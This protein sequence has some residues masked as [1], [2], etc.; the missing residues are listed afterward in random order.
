MAGW[1]WRENAYVIKDA[2][3]A[4]KSSLN[5]LADGT[6]LSFTHLTH[7]LTSN[8]QSLKE[9]ALI[10]EKILAELNYPT[11][12][13]GQ[14]VDCEMADG[15]IGYAVPICLLD[16]KRSYCGCEGKYER[17]SCTY[18]KLGNG[19]CRNSNTVKCCVE[20]CSTYLDLVIL[21]DSSGSIG[22][23][24]FKKEQQFVKFLINSLEIG[25][26]ASR[27]SIIDFSSN[28]R[29][30]IKLINGTSN[31]TLNQAVD[32]ITYRGGSN[33]LI[34]IFKFCFDKPK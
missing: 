33:F 15:E 1:F 5:Q 2:N 28:A 16:H 27:V 14:G 18:G 26:N 3:I 23:A 7:S 17:T 10:N 13:R 6:F 21:M 22:S 30:I 20:R 9:R 34:Q 8:L 12:K 29:I 24:D 32:S 19:Q 31:I 11:M 25:Q 4:K